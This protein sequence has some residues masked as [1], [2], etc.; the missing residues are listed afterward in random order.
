[1]CTRNERYES[2]LVAILFSDTVLPN[3]F[4]QYIGPTALWQPKFLTV[5]AL[6]AIYRIQAWRGVL[7]APEGDIPMP[8]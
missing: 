3:K 1:M 2:T 7:V 4:F 8:I 5:R 6:C